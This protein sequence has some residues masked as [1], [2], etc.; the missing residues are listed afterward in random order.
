MAVGKKIFN[1]RVVK[2]V[3]AMDSK[4]ISAR[5]DGSSPSLGTKCNKVFKISEKILY[6]K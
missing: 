5:S 1:A 3:D 2:L 4:S 6:K